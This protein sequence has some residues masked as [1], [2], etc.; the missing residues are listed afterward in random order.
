MRITETFKKA[1]G[2]LVEFDE[3]PKPDAEWNVM[4]AAAP[5]APKAAA[6]A[7]TP[8]PAKTIEQI[9]RE[10]PGPNL[11]EIKPTVSPTQPVI[12]SAGHVNFGAIY[13]Q[14]TLP[15]VP[16]TAEQV[17]EILASLPA[18]LPLEAKRAT[19][20]VTLGAMGK[21][22]GATPETVVA[23]ASR[24]LAALAAYA[25]NYAQQADEYVHRCEKDI[26][27]LQQ[28]IERRRT[29]IEDAKGK[30]VQMVDACTHESDRLD[31]VLEFFS[32]DV[33]PSKYANPG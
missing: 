24:K 19:L 3:T 23:D 28:E 8:A 12:D 32:L 5:E 22:I 20:K 21:T 2:L 15:N 27:S 26:E 33:G 29:A 17:L 9:V 16:F 4:D 31:D 13:Q 25:Q 7:P 6:P 18:E 30:K 14:A 1:A 10:T 11:D